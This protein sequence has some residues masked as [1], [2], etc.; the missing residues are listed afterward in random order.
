[1]TRCGTLV[2]CCSGWFR[3]C[4]PG[5]IH[6]QL[7]GPHRSRT[8]PAGASRSRF[9]GKPR[10]KPRTACAVAWS[11]SIHRPF[12]IPGHGVRCRHPGRRTAALPVLVVVR[13]Q[14]RSADRCAGLALG[15][16]DRAGG[17]GQG[18]ARSDPRRPVFSLF[19]HPDA[20]AAQT[21][22]DG[23]DRQP[24]L[25]S[26]TVRS[27]IE[28]RPS[29]HRIVGRFHPGSCPTS[30][31]SAPA[32]QPAGARPLSAPHPDRATGQGAGKI[33][34]LVRSARLGTAP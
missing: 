1:M 16:A 8:T 23:A 5:R 34:A 4:S 28:L 12:G 17:A 18:A 33:V 9:T 30:V 19:G 13:R 27:A 22:A 7:R 20:L 14:E 26:L 10:P 6:G 15:P 2:T 11:C 24:R 25:L 29:P 21:T 31:S 32:L 3:P